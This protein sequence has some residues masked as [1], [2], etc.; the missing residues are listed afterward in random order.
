MPEI[1]EKPFLEPQ[2]EYETKIELL[3]NIEVESQII[4]HCMHTSFF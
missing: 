3:S 1:I 4:I 2:I